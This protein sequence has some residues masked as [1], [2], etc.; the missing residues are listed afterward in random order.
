MK[1]FEAIVRVESPTGELLANDVECHVENCS[2]IH[3]LELRFVSF[4][5]VLLK[6]AEVGIMSLRMKGT[7]VA[8]FSKEFG[9]ANARDV[10][11]V[12]SP[13]RIAMS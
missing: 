12:E 2:T 11:R 7:D 9:Q 6:S 1:E 10:L 4:E 5:M 3:V 13:I 8:L